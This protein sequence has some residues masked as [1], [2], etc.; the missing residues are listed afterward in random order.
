VVI[1]SRTLKQEFFD[2]WHEDAVAERQDAAYRGL[3]Q[4]MYAGKPRQDFV[5][6]A[7]A[8]RCT[9]IANPLILEV[10]CGSGYYSEILPHLLRH[11]VRYVGLDYSPAMIRLA[12]KR[13]SDYPFVVG[14]A[15]ALPF[16]DGS[17]DTILNGV[18]LMHILGYESAISESRRVTRRW[19]IFHTVPVLQR[20]ETT[21]LRKRA[22]GGTTVEIIFNQ[23]QLRNHL[24]QRGLVVRHVL[25][26]IPYNLEAVLNERTVTRT[27]V[28]EVKGK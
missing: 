9:G 5:V 7:D 27:Y 25:D 8:V 26:S 19:C 13:Y 1:D 4:Q 15:T 22:Y 20:R 6:A 23:E 28:C 14:D 16:P 12:R 11:S 3:I 2:G 21:V 17:F 10:G 18:S 24:E